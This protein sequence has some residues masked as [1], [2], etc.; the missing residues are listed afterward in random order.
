[1]GCSGS[2]PLC[3]NSR[4]VQ[5]TA[6]A[7]CPAGYVAC[8]NS[9]CV[10]RQ[11]DPNNLLANPGLETDLSG[12]SVNDG[13]AFKAWNSA[14]ADN[15][16]A[17]GSLKV[18]GGQGDVSQCLPIQQNTPYIAGLKFKQDTGGAF[19]CSVS[20]WGDSNCNTDSIFDPNNPG[21][22]RVDTPATN[23][24]GVSLRYFPPVGATFAQF[25]CGS[26]GTAFLDQFFFSTNGSF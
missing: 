3:V 4:C 21:Q 13:A 10:C 26:G 6:L 18:S 2:T 12:W 8:V 24:T 1:M 9:S 22:L 25:L 7:N 20:F 19:T 23:W 14:D 17:S 11:K 5:C 16:P 15:C